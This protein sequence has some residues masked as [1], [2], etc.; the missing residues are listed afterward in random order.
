M[1]VGGNQ[2]VSAEAE[3]MGTPELILSILT[4]AGGHEQGCFNVSAG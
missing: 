3:A 4:D 1:L 2:S